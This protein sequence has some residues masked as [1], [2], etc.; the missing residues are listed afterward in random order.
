MLWRAMPFAL[1]AWLGWL[2][3]R[4]RTRYHPAARVGETVLSVLFLGLFW[5]MSGAWALGW[6]A[7]LGEQREVLVVGQIVDKQVRRDRHGEHHGLTLTDI[8]SQRL[9]EIPTDPASFERLRL[10]DPVGF[11]LTRGSLGIYYRPR[12]DEMVRFLRLDRIRRRPEKPFDPQMLLE[13]LEEQFDL[14]AILVTGQQ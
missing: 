8:E 5:L 11:A 14:P 13:P 10:G 4:W 7:L 2:L 12:W 3:W 6:N 9:V 1:A